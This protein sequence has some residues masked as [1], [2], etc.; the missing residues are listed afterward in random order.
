MLAVIRGLRGDKH[1]GDFYVDLMRIIGFVFIPYCLILALFLVASGVP[2]TFDGAVKAT[3]LDGV[4]AKMDTQTIARG[5]VAALVADQADR[6]QR[7]RLLRA[8]LGAP[9]R[10]S[11]ALEQPARDQSRSSIMPMASIVMLGLMLKNR[12]H[13]A[14]IYGVD[15]G[16]ARSSA[17]PWPIYAEL[18]PSAATERLAGRAERR[19]WKARRC[20]S[21][22]SPRRP[23]RR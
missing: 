6:H 18:S 12:A 11:H 16:A 9:V 8:E 3:P 20:A 15:A 1:M 2:M 21:A 7:R 4:A 10:E 19:T 5:P 17:W 22:R 23:G 13:A 14:V